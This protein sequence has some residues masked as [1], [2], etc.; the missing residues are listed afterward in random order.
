MHSTRR[1]AIHDAIVR[2]ADGDRSAL[3]ALLDELWPVLLAFAERGVGRGAD[4]EDVAQEAF[5]KICARTADF[6]RE[7]DGLS[8]AFGIAHF[9]VLTHR[10]RRQRRREVNTG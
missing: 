8:W 1:K 4:A 10:R 7:R 3:D 6:D 5:I 9:E 2:L